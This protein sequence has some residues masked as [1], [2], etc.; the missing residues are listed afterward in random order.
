MLA[1]DQRSGGGEYGG[2]NRTVT[3]LGRSASYDAA[4]PDLEA[5]L[6]WG[7]AHANGAPLLLW[8]SS[9]SAALVFVLASQHP[10]DVQG[11]LAFSQRV[12]KPDEP[13]PN[14]SIQGMKTPR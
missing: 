8:G 2:K 5:A 11:L 6:A 10:A 1:I 12:P 9:Y 14:R 13:E 4:L 7:R 3:A